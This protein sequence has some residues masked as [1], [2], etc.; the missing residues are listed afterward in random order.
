MTGR[1]KTWS[2]VLMFLF[3]INPAAYG[4]GN[5]KNA[6]AA[7][8]AN[9]PVQQLGIYLDAFH[10]MKD[11]PK[12]QLE[13]HHY[14]KAVNDSFLQ[15]AIFDGND[16]AANLNGI[17]YIVSEKVYESLPKDEQKY[18][19]PHN[20]EILSGQLISPGMSGSAEKEM[21]KGKMNSYGKTWHVWNSKMF[22]KKGDKLPIGEPMLAWSFNHD[23]EADAGMVKARD[24]NLKVDT[25]KKKQERADLVSVANPQDGV[26]AMKSLFAEDIKS[27]PGVK[28]KKSQLAGTKGK[29]AGKR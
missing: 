9:G 22:K 17:E 3:A 19:H 7:P 11:D 24:K 13:A 12:H 14:C 10:V 2:G 5:E 16:Q 25:E 4:C 23:G 26:D 28:D 21:L 15:C 18:W 1:I 29:D 8:Q 6:N 27:I 20:Y